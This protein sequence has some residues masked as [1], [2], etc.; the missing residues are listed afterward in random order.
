MKSV[1]KNPFI[2]TTTDNDKRIFED[3]VNAVPETMTVSEISEYLSYGD[4]SFKFKGVQK[5]NREP[6]ASRIKRHISVRD[7]NKK[8]G[9]INQFIDLLR[10]MMTMD[11]EE[12]F[13]AS[14]CINHPFFDKFKPFYEDMRKKYPPVKKSDY[15]T[16]IID[17]V[18]RKWAA[19]A[20]FE[21]YNKR[22]SLEFGIPMM[23]YF[24]LLDYLTNIS[25]TLLVEKTPN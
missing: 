2:T 12:R 8:G 11:P 21:I 15:E 5:V 1:T 9:S 7:F 6:F 4:A 19:N 23:S 22:E 13:S 18:E 16:V 3:I 10:N 25:S 24:T 20:I 17:C 14:E